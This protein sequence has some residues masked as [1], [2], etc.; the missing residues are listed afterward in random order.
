MATFIMAMGISTAI[1][2]MTAGFKQLD[3]ARNITLSSQVL[4]SEMERIRLMNW[5]DVAAISG[6]S[7]VDLSA[8]FT[9]D[10]ALAARFT[11]TRTITDVAG[12]VGEMKQVALACGW[13]GMDGRSHTRRFTTFYTKNG[14]Y[15]YYYTLARP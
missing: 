3:V 5:T 10:A 11:L 13:T 4:Q 9:D 8:V 12:K 2:G 14:L 7:T 15:D 6:T 1:V